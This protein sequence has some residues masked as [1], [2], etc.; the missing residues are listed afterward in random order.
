MLVKK[1]SPD[2]TPAENPFLEVGGIIEI[3]NAETLLRDGDV[4]KVDAPQKPEESQESQEKKV[5]PKDNP[6]TNCAKCGNEF[7]RNHHRTKYCNDCKA[8]N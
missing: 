3:D 2:W 7:I 4:E 5:A 8:K 1:V 6:K